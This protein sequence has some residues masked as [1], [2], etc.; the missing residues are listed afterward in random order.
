MTTDARSAWRRE[1]QKLKEHE[2]GTYPR[3]CALTAT[4]PA[5]RGP[6]I[7]DDRPAA[8][9]AASRW[10]RFDFREVHCTNV[11]SMQ[12]ARTAAPTYKMPIIRES[13]RNSNI[14]RSDRPEQFQCRAPQGSRRRRCIARSRSIAFEISRW[15]PSSSRL[16]RP[17]AR[18]TREYLYRLLLWIAKETRYIPRHGNIR[19]P[20]GQTCGTS[21]EKKAFL[22]QSLLCSP[23]R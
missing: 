4:A 9:A 13:T 1:S 22:R 5:K 14:P 11:D 17:I 3:S 20:A 18:R 2:I 12:S 6:T 16:A 8:A 15:E 19:P 21:Q 10:P 7:S 23:P